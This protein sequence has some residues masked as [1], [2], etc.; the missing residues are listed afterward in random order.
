MSCNVFRHQSKSDF[1]ME[2]LVSSWY[3]GQTTI[4]KK[5]AWPVGL[6]PAK[7]SDA[8]V[9]KTL[10]VI[11]LSLSEGPGRAEIIHQIIQASQEFGFFQVHF[12]QF[13]YNKNYLKMFHSFFLHVFR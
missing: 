2:T 4:P 1:T 5:Y 7:Q 8:P 13:P 6:R 12:K 9:C 11:D 10:P 3:N